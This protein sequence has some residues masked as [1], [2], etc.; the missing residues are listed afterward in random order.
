MMD[1]YKP[2]AVLGR[3]FKKLGD[4][5]ESGNAWGDW[6]PKEFTVEDSAFGMVTMEN[7]AA[8]ILESSWAINL[9]DVR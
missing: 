2:K 3:A 8:I 5:K 9:L 6:D 1:N 4:Q 7:G